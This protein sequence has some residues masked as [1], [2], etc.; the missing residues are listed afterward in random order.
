MPPNVPAKLDLGDYLPYLA[1]RVGTI[2]ADQF[3][4]EALAAHGLS[5]AMW[6][7][8][9][10]LAS[11]GSQRQID[12]AEL[13]SIDASTLSRL[14]SRLV[15][16]GLVARTRS[17]R[18]NREVAVSLSAKGNAL[19][20]RLVPIAREIEAAAIAGLQPDELIVLKRCLR[21]MYGNMKSRATAG[22]TPRPKRLAG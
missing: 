5:I 18:S 22:A 8:I 3:G 17:S 16:M 12:L 19:V 2:I 13:T 4:D 15:R 7:V 10:A 1:N 14:V 20:A 9:A 6:R 11:A 21:R